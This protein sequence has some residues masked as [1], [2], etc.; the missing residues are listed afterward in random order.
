M[1]KISLHFKKFTNSLA[2]N[3][4]ILR[5]KNA[6]D[7]ATTEG[8]KLDNMTSWYGPKQFLREPIHILGSQRSC[9][10][11]IFMSQPNLPVDPDMHPFLA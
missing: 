8:I 11:L 3:S 2:N 7:G 6:Y 4:R 10:N 9:V 5:T 1:L